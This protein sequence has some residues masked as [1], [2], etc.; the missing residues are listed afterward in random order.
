MKPHR[1]PPVPDCGEAGSAHTLRAY[2]HDVGELVSH[3]RKML[4]RAPTLAS[5]TLAC[6]APTLRRSM[7]E[8]RRDIGRSCPRC[9]RSS[10]WPSAGV[11]F[12]EP[13][14]RPAGT[15]ARPAAA[16]V[17]GQGRRRPVARRRRPRAPT[18][19]PPSS[20]SNARCSRSS[21]A[22]GCA[23][24]RPAVSTSVT[25]RS[26]APAPTCA[27]ARARAAR[28]A[29]CRWVARRARRWTRTAYTA[30]TLPEAT[31]GTPARRCSSAAAACAWAA[32]G[33]PAARPARHATGTPRGLAARPPPQL[34]D[35][36]ARRRGRPARD[37]G[38]ARTRQPAY[39]AALRPRRHRPPHEGLRQIPPARGDREPATDTID[40]GAGG[41]AQRARRASAA[42]A[43]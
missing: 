7:D 5:L 4:G 26:T 33:P 10:G 16:L 36:P 12:G 17:P 8:R 43:R 37:P 22:P 23:S 40:D 41:S 21:T 28:I 9:A 38:D 31:G 3:A 30:A 35:P 24:P 11:F 32:R 27:C 39:H 15:Q 20:R 42:T 19:T 13:R 1:L 6:A 34:R 29:S 18:R 25:S 2:L 14:R